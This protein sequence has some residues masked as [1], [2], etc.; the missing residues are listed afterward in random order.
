LAKA[1]T[2]K[3]PANNTSAGTSSRHGIRNVAET[4][5]FFEMKT[6]NEGNTGTS[7]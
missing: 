1:W 5:N 6:D 7:C 2:Y 4:W 3:P